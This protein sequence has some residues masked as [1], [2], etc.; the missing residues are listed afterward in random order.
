MWTHY[1]EFQLICTDVYV[2]ICTYV[3][4]RIVSVSSPLTTPRLNCI[5]PELCPSQSF[6]LISWLMICCPS[7]SWAVVERGPRRSP[8]DLLHHRKQPEARLRLVRLQNVRHHRQ[9]R[10][11]VRPEA[12]GT[13]TD[14]SWTVENPVSWSNGR[15]RSV[16]GLSAEFFRR[17]RRSSELGCRVWEW[18]GVCVS[19]RLVEADRC[20]FY[21]SLCLCVGI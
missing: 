12:G 17:C 5:L 9:H 18:P 13:R 11:P 4:V 21:D 1:D 2:R 3:Y 14:L 7:F 20:F 15:V 16:S 6:V 10:H 19:C 8:A